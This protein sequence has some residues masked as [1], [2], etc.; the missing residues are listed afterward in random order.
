M[1]NSTNITKY[2][3]LAP[4]YDLF[5]GPFFTKERKRA[6]GLLNMHPGDKILLAGIGTGQDLPLLQKDC[7]I[8]GID[9]SDTMLDRAKEKA[10]NRNA[11]LLNM[12]A[13][14]L[15]FSDGEFDIVILNLVL[16][17]VESPHQALSEALR[18]LKT[19]G[20]ILVFDKFVKSKKGITIF[21]MLINKFTSLL[22]TDITRYFE[23]ITEG[24]PVSL[25][26]DEPSMMNGNYR[27]I[28][29]KKA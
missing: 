29:L 22:A 13:E 3:L 11:K 23:D 25:I 4:I 20:R 5:F 12:N 26:K 14:N 10:K 28:L 6:I 7:L 21:R 8:I 1:K 15:E 16:S 17:V 24:L 18:V 19:D 9:I 27:I 2:R